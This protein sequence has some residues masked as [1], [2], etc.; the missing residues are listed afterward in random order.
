MPR[1]PLSSKCFWISAWILCACLDVADEGVFANEQSA[2]EKTLSNSA[3]FMGSVT[4]PHSRASEPVLLLAAAER[5]WPFMELLLPCRACEA[6]DALSRFGMLF[7]LVVGGMIVGC[8][9]GRGGRRAFHRVTMS[10]L[11]ATTVGG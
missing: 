4:W 3:C 2:K 11:P 10:S 9:Y 8:K 7:V 1:G 6:A 5:L